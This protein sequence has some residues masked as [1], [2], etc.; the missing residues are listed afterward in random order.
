MNKMC[1][2]HFVHFSLFDVLLNLCGVFFHDLSFCKNCNKT[3][4]TTGSLISMD[5]I[6]KRR[7]KLF[8]EIE[9]TGDLN[10]RP[11]YFNGHLSYI[12]STLTSCPKGSY[13][14]TKRLDYHR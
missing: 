9:F 12:D 11:M 10:K 13:L 7:W 5:W 2:C 6:S 8:K 14:H 3:V 1:F 4:S